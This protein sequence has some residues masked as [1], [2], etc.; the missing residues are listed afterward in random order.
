[1][2]FYYKKLE[3]YKLLQLRKKNIKI[4]KFRYEL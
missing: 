3:I 1:M 4:I 2:I